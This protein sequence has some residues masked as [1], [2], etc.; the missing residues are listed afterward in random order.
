[1]ILNPSVQRRFAVASRAVAAIGGGYVLA[2][3]LAIFLVR[4]LPLPPP[5]VLMSSVLLTFAFYACAAIWAF[6][7]RSALRAWAGI[8][9]PVLVCAAGLWFQGGV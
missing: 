9:I 4:M 7:A 3:T 2:N 1:M 6:A 8:S 5:A